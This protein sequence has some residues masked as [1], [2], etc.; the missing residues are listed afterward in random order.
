MNDLRDDISDAGDLADRM[1]GHVNQ[2][3]GAIDLA[4]MQMQLRSAMLAGE[5]LE[6]LLADLAFDSEDHYATDHMEQALWN[7]HRFFRL[8]IEAL[9]G[10]QEL[11]D[12]KISAMR[13]LAADA[14][15]QVRAVQGSV[16]MA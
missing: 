7:L 8:G 2:A 11:L 15:E 14:R 1:I 10:D 6:V 13:P 3:S 5:E 16:G 9:S 4:E 12:A